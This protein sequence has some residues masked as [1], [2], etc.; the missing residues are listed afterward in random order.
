LLE[1]LVVLLILALL[2]GAAAGP[3]REGMRRARL[4]SAATELARRMMAAR[5]QAVSRHASIGLRFEQEGDGW[6]VVT[7]LDGDADGIRSRDIA[8]GTDLPMG[9]VYRP[10]ER[11]PGVRFG[12]PPGDPVPRIPPARGWLQPGDDPIRFG[13]SDI[14]SFSP[15]GGVTPG[16][17]YLTDDDGRLAALVVFGATARMRLRFFHRGTGRWV[18]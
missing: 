7:Y 15:L 5:W 4:R 6:R 9:T 16:T 14:V 2:A 1:L 18:G 3:V 8:S 13:R 12:L 17:V 10:Q 11:R